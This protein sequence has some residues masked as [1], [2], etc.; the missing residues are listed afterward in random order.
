MGNKREPSLNHAL[1]IDT[2]P[3]PSSIPSVDEIGASSA[4]LLSASYFIGAR[5]A[6]YNDDFMLCKEQSKDGGEIECLKEG[7]RV[8]RCAS[9]VIKDLNA[10][11]KESFQLHYECLNNSNY[12]LY[13]CR[14]AEG[15]LNDC[16]FKSLGLKK[17]IPGVEEQIHLKKNPIY[18]A[19]VQDR[20]SVLAYEGLKAKEKAGNV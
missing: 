9:S 20:P 12:D 10:H 7:R 13:K 2:A 5:C 19:I 15:M 6:P 16:V 18:K 8:T 3:L 11:C 1:L 17:V 14:L 4:P